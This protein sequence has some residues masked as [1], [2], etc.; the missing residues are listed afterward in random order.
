LLVLAG[1]YVG[2]LRR[3]KRQAAVAAPQQSRPAHDPAHRRWG[4]R[5]SGNASGEECHAER[6]EPRGRRPHLLRGRGRRRAA[7]PLLHRLRGAARCC[8]VRLLER[9]D[10]LHGVAAGEARVPSTASSDFE[11]T[12]LGSCFQIRANSSSCSG[13]VGLRSSAVSQ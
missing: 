7:R 1:I 11:Y 2:A 9:R 4:D 8:E 3:P 6:D 13:A 10:L 5:A 12:S